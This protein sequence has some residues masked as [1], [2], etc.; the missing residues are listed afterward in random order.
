MNTNIWVMAVIA[1]GIMMILTISFYLSIFFDKNKQKKTSDIINNNI[2]RWL[3][4][5]LGFSYT[6]IIL[7]VYI[8]VSKVSNI[9]GLLI[10]SINTVI[11]MFAVTGLLLFT[12]NYTGNEESSKRL[13]SLGETLFS[14]SIQL[15]I[16]NV[17]IG[18]VAIII[19]I[20]FTNSFNS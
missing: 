15:L 14:I 10:F 6:L 11:G 20:M 8:I 12:N 17:F 3:M 13:V 1:L 9:I 5:L 18:L 16:G 4:F 19:T 7:F 2:L